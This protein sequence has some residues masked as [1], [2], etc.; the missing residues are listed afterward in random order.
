MSPG[1]MASR[2]YDGCVHPQVA[3]ALSI[4]SGSVPVFI[5]GNLQLTGPDS[6]ENAPKL[7]VVTGYEAVTSAIAANE[8][9]SAI[10]E[11]ILRFIKN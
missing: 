9:P 7:Y 1:A 2:G 8:A 4:D 5:T 11:R 6:S 3:R 10:I